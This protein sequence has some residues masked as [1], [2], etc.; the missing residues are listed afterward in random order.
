LQI[1]ASV[2][3]SDRQTVTY[4][5]KGISFQVRDPR[6]VDR[7]TSIGIMQSYTNFNIYIGKRFFNLACLNNKTGYVGKLLSNT[8]I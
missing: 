1:N 8:N 4:R 7:I 6:C 3:V 2:F 5:F